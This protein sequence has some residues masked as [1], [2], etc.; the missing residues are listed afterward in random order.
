MVTKGVQPFSRLPQVM[1]DRLLMTDRLQVFVETETV[2][3]WRNLYKSD[4][5]QGKLNLLLN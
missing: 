4:S 5:K 2:V 1:T 3:Q